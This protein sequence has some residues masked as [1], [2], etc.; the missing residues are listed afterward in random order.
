MLNLLTICT[1]GRSFSI[2]DPE[3]LQFS[4]LSRSTQRQLSLQRK[5]TNGVLFPTRKRANRIQLSPAEAADA[6]WWAVH[7]N[8]KFASLKERAHD[9]GTE[10]SSI[11][12]DATGTWSHEDRDLARTDFQTAGKRFLQSR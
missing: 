1:M 12:A 5:S 10:L 8:D 6:E 11:A 4:T 9:S 7:I 2:E 3:E